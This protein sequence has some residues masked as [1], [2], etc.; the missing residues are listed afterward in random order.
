MNKLSIILFF[1]I[2]TSS[3]YCYNVPDEFK[4]FY[5]YK[6][7][8]VVIK[9]V[10]GIKNDLS[11]LMNYNSVKINSELAKKELSKFL[12]RLG[13][14]DEL[15]LT[16]M[17]DFSSNQGVS[18][19][20]KCIGLARDCL[21]YPKTY[22][23]VFDYEKK[24]IYFYI[25]PDYLNKKN[26]RLEFVNNIDTN[27]AIINS[28]NVFIGSN[29]S[30]NSMTVNNKNTVG[31]NYGY[32]DSDFSYQMNNKN[33]DSFELRKLA[34]ILDYQSYQVQIG[35]FD[36]NLESNST[37]FLTS[38]DNNTKNISIN[39]RDSKNLISNKDLAYSSL[40]FYTPSSGYLTIKKDDLIVFQKNV[41]A[42]VGEIPYS[43]LPT[44]VYNIELSIKSNGVEVLK[45]NLYV[46]NIKSGRLSKKDFDS[47][48]SIGLYSEESQISNLD[49]IKYE[50]LDKFKGMGFID[51]SIAYGI[52]DAAM[53][54]SE[55]E[56]TDDNDFKTKIGLSYL[57]EN[58]SKID[59]IYSRYKDGSYSES[60]N[61]VTP[62]FG[63]YYD[64]FDFSEGDLFALYKEGGYSRKSA[65]LNKN[66]NITPVL[67]A[68]LNYHYNEYSTSSTEN[69]A[70][71]IATSLDYRF[72][73]GSIFNVQIMYDNSKTEY[74]EN[75]QFIL[76]AS[77][78]I[79][80]GDDLTYTSYVSTYDN[81]FDE[82]RNEISSDNIIDSKNSVLDIS[83]GHSIYT[84]SY[85]SNKVYAN[86]TGNYNDDKLN[87]NMYAYFD[88]DGESNL[89]VSLSNTQIITRDDIY[90]TSKESTSYLN[91]DIKNDD[92][93]VKNLGLLTV[94]NKNK[95]LK[96]KFLDKKKNIIPL[97]EYIQFSGNLDTT[98]V[99]LEN[100][101]EKEIS[102]FSLP[103]SVY[104]L[105][106]NVGKIVT[107]VA[108]FDDIFD[109]DINN[110]ECEGAGCVDIE[111]IEGNV[112]NIKVRAGAEFMLY[113]DSL[114]CLT[115]KV[116]QIKNLNIGLNHCV[117][118]VEDYDNGIMLAGPDGSLHRVY[119]VGIFNKNDKKTLKNDRNINVIETELNDNETLVFVSYDHDY[120]LSNNDK[121]F[122]KKM[123]LT[124]RN[125]KE[126]SPFV[127]ELDESWFDYK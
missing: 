30:T 67:N 124:A 25:S 96:K 106:P 22:G 23:I 87:S 27:P 68:N 55:F 73:A 117:P 89:S 8:V 54:G 122:I 40:S 12:K 62:W 72:N 104:T 50:S 59:V 125:H 24:V 113:S 16:I 10:D 107:F 51:S 18:S 119:F 3:V 121:S 52:T 69:K 44:G 82:F 127:L 76:N 63:F 41:K 32:I 66:F 102:G 37:S 75:D 45:Q 92:E 84:E 114:V 70:W 56:I 103:G 94:S 81:S 99:S 17:N 7:D 109:Q 33:N 115:P 118:D 19:S 85:K 78:S 2:F 126:I 36:G 60:V 9:S 61:L 13:V 58:S 5:D 93:R 71:N 11:A 28:Y 57:F 105:R 111:N 47:S 83:T 26:E 80:F 108:A 91:I 116:K 48:A 101:G 97:E 43:K 39:I 35:S 29:N 110:I 34:Y 77:V 86:I 14:N 31:L 20:D 65:S 15:S 1:T 4:E 21:L 90:F 123:M 120:I 95:L 53:F 6:E 46:Y 64:S 49:E 42:G 112:F 88:S 79:P 74:N 100:N 98:S 38:I